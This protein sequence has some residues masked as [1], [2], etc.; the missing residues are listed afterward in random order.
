MIDYKYTLNLPHTKFPMRANLIS[1]ELEMLDNW[2]E[3]DLYKLIRFSKK[4]KE[5]FFL[6]DGPPYVNGNVHIGH[7]VNKILKD[8]IIKFKGLMGFDA[9]YIPGWDCHGLPVELKVEQ[10][11]RSSSKCSDKV[12]CAEFRLMCRNYAS[13]QVM[14]QKKDF[15][16]LGVLGNWQNSYL[17]MNFV[18]EANIIRV[19]S[20][21]INNG[22]IYKGIKPVH[23]CINCC[24]V[25]AEAE[26]EYCDYISP[27]IYV[28][29]IAKDIYEVLAKFGIKRSNMLVVLVVWTTTP[30]SLPDNRALTVH[31][32]FD[33]QLVEINKQGFIISSFAVEKIMKDMNFSHWKILGTIKGS[34]LEYIK[35]CHPF[36]NFDV[37][38]TLG[39]HV[40]WNVGTGIIHTAPAHGIDDYV[41]AQRYQLEVFDSITADGYYLA[42]T[43]PELDGIQCFEANDV[44]IDL[45][46]KKGNLLYV[47]TIEHSYPHCWRHA[48]PL[49]FRTTPQWFI[50]L[51]KNNLR[52]LMLAEIEKVQWMPAREKLRMQSMVINRPDWCISRQ[53]IWGVP[54]PVFVHKNTHDLHPR[55]VEVMEHIASLVERQGVQVW[56]DVNPVDLI[57]DDVLNYNKVTD[58]LD[59]WFD[60]GSSNFSALSTQFEHLGEVSDLYFE[61][62]DQCRG[63]FM[64]ALMLSVAITKKAP[65]KQV[66]THGFVVD[67]KGHKM[68]KSIGNVIN[69]QVIVNKL[70]ADVLRL[71]V[72]STNYTNDIT[73]S[74]EILKRSIDIYR[75]IRNTARF[76]LSNISDFDPSIHAVRPECMILL[77]RWAVG[78]AYSLQ[79]NIISAYNKYNF[80]CV[81]KLIMHFCSIDMG[82]FYLDVIKDRQYTNQA[83]SIARRSCQTALYHIIEAMVRWISP[84]LSFTSS[85][86]WKYLPGER[87]KY[88][89]TE[90]WYSNLFDIDSA[91][92]M[93]ND[94]WDILLQVRNEVNRVIAQACSEG[95]IK[96]S[97][98][99]SV[100]LYAEPCLAKKL[101]AL[102]HELDFLLLTS[103]AT[104]DDYV[105][106]YKLKKIYES[107]DGLKIFLEKARGTKCFRCWHY[108][109]DVGECSNYPHLCNRCISNMFG[110]GECRKFV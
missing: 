72:A 104:V 1:S 60:S 66:L 19:L 52:T 37:P 62:V 40:S 17:T 25:L 46:N 85:E 96:S 23:W 83:N 65:Y 22:H 8:I 31:P 7:A 2:Y 56:W 49:I 51:D 28:M 53:R 108:A 86:I 6:H 94:Y 50:S 105:N 82:S 87:A 39:E 64:A 57:G 10:L 89:F 102:G 92:L 36:M 42:N 44:I 21:V 84:I 58:V 11:T 95:L 34:E 98:E 68:S 4:G 59:V 29:F 9:P 103:A 18:T 54:I 38:V 73:I 110:T 78:Q 33:Y 100:V 107:F 20:K 79:K 93:N 15:I 88:V 80:H 77:D 69:P 70:G 71:W 63:W 61:G 109:L 12:N 32:N 13:K 14:K 26:V 27:S 45:L 99:A 90:E 48:S 81:I 35:F 43:F 41:I 101:R 24:S 74:N 91:Q 55:T 106:H 3:D 76:L 47:K 67:Y 97:L 16:R 5:I 30:W 75:R